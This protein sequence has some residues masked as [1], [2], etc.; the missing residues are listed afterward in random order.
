MKQ[1]TQRDVALHAGVSRATVSYVVSPNRESPVPISEKT[2]QKVLDAVRELGYQ[3]DA[4]AQTLIS[5]ATR[6]IGILLPDMQNPHFWELMEAIERRAHKRGY[7]LLVYHSALERSQ[8]ELALQE[9]GRRR[10]DGVV[11]ISSFPPYSAE[12]ADNLGATRRPVVDLSNVESPFDCVIS[13]YDEGAAEM[14]EHLFALGHRRIG[15]VYGV[16][17]PE[18]GRDR[19]DAYTEAIRRRG[20]PADETLVARCGT[21][22]AEGY[23]AARTLL[24]RAARPT[25][26][27]AINDLIAMSVLRAAADLGISVP[28]DLSVC[29]FDDVPGA[30]FAVPRLTTVDRDAGEVADSALRLLLSRMEDKSA[31]RMSAR[32]ACRL[33]VRETTGQAPAG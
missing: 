26:I 4:R 13:S 33:V 16:A 8:E 25:A 12:V 21:S 20:L 15:F 19:L 9:L 24:T 2:R 10:I 30:R 5:G 23:D 32:I 28:R 3:P 6:I 17:S 1:T 22:A 11:L 14:M 29:G 27:I 31:P 18:L 7:S